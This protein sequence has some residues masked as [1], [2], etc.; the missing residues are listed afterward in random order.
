M[1]SRNARPFPARRGP[2]NKRGGRLPPRRD[3]Q[4]RFWRAIRAGLS[5]E[6]ASAC[7]GIDKRT[8]HYWFSKAGGMAPLSL[9]EPVKTRTL[10]IAEREKIL[11]GINHVSRSGRSLPVS[12][13]HPRRSAVSWPRTWG[14]STVR[15]LV[16]AGGPGFGGGTTPRTWR[17]D[18]PTPAR[19]DPRSPSWPITRGCAPRCRIGWNR[20][21]VPSRSR[22]GCGWSSLTNRRCGCH[23]RRSTSRCTSRAAARC[24]V[25]CTSG[26]GPGMRCENPTARPAS[27]AAGS[28]GWST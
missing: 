14:R 23:T 3:Y 9:V 25:T 26:C 16:V 8:G 10:N 4:R 1:S 7:L 28:R 13:G 27:D 22:P 6:G 5:V 24:A 20:S 15:F 21:T 12:V 19:N 11:A 17:S 2:L 18:E